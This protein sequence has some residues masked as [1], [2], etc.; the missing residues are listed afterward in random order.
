VIDSVIA[1]AGRHV[2]A[3]HYEVARVL[4]RDDNSRLGQLL[5]TLIYNAAPRCQPAK[6]HPIALIGSTLCRTLIL[7]LGKPN[8]PLA[9]VTSATNAAI[10]MSPVMPTTETEQLGTI[11]T[12]AKK[13]GVGHV[14]AND[15]K[16][17]TFSPSRPK[18]RTVRVLA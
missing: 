9:S 5:A 7:C 8:R 16:N 18:V 11:R 4:E 2:A 1:F 15:A 6:P 12:S 3:L 14:L 17:L 13:K 10:R